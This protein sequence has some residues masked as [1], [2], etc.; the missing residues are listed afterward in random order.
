[1]LTLFLFFFLGNRASNRPDSDHPYLRPNP[2]MGHLH[3]GQIPPLI[4]DS[5]LA[6]SS[7]L[8]L[9]G[10]MVA[11]PGCRPPNMADVFPSGE[12]LSLSLSFP[13]SLSNTS[14]S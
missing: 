13:L 5:R 10:A 7:G 1:M 6:P 8:D 3:P 12:S 14:M 2:F 11:D 9:N 4:K